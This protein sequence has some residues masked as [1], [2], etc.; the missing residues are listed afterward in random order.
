MCGFPPKPPGGIEF[1]SFGQ[2]DANSHKWSD[3]GILR[4]FGRLPWPELVAGAVVWA[5]ASW[6]QQWPA[7][8][9]GELELQ[10]VSFD[11]CG[12]VGQEDNG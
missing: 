7:K 6:P 11:I 10:G 2:G 1:S 5:C 9:Q 4:A 8:S 12:F 3:A